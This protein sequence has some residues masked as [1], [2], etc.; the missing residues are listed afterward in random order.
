MIKL[1]ISDIDG[2][3]LEEGT[4][5]IDP[6]L[7]DAIR[8]LKKKGVLFVAAS[9]RQYNSMLHVMRPVAEDILFVAENGTNIVQNGKSIYS[10]YIEPSLS[11]EAVRY[12]KTI[13]ECEVTVSTPEMMY[14]ENTNAELVELLTVGYQNAVTI[15]DDV[16]PFSKNASKMAIHRK[17]GSDAIA[18]DIKNKFGDRLN[19]AIAGSVWVDLIHKDA[20]K[21]FAL[22][23][24]QEM[25]HISKEETMAFGD[26]CN[27]IGMLKQAG[28][29]YAVANAHPELK[30]VAKHEALSY[31]EDGVL[32]VLLGLLEK[33]E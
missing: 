23:K 21:G 25:L 2:T 20:D 14:M 22:K 3:L 33:N 9:G 15:V 1:V 16:I 5:Q 4:A 18:D 32:K 26:N 12:L 13:P 31:K 6:R 24:L 10:Q 11:E 30:K 8:Q 19:V 28:E 27:D 7:F 29:S 17:A